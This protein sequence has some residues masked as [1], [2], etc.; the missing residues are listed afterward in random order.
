MKKVLIIFGGNSTEHYISCK[1]AKSIVENIDKRLFSYE[2]AGIDLCGEWFKFNDDLSFLENGNWKDGNVFKIDNIIEYLKAFDVVFPITHGNNGEDGKLQGFL[3]L[4]NIKYVGSKTTSSVV[5]FDKSL[6]KLVF[7]YL[8]IPQ[9]PYVVVDE[10]YKVSS[11]VSA[12]DFPMIVKPCSGGSSIGISRVNNKKELSKAIKNSLK[13][14]DKVIIEKFVNCR[15]LECALLGNSDYIISDLGEI[16]SCNDFY[17]YDAKYVQKS[18]TFIPNDLP[19]D[20]VEKIKEYA[21]IIFE[22]MYIKDYCRIDFFYD[23]CDGSIYINE[24][25]TIPGFTTISMYP[26]LIN[27]ENISYMDLISILINNS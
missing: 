11:V 24:I 14:D 16:K 6:S 3:D 10:K 22:K 25:N 13:Y 18:E 26:K 20:I 7:G 4:F 15:E 8:N 17:D 19:I 27:N 21:G 9:V 1:S 5:G 12:L 23:E 2:L